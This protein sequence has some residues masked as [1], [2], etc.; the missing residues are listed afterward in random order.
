[1]KVEVRRGQRQHKSCP[2][3]SGCYSS[4]WITW[5]YNPKAHLWSVTALH[6]LICSWITANS[7]LSSS[8][9]HLTNALLKTPGCWHLQE[10]KHVCYRKALHTDPSLFLR[11]RIML[12]WTPT[13]EATSSEKPPDASMICCQTPGAKKPQQ[14]LSLFRKKLQ[15]RKWKT[16]TGPPSLQ[17]NS[18]GRYIS[19]PSSFWTEIVLWMVKL[20]STINV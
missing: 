20:L 1:M 5:H 8:L 14:I 10:G 11:G 12:C 9:E 4:W 6:L 15:L 7:M 13:G 2:D 16:N 17:C 18:H 19:F 3:L